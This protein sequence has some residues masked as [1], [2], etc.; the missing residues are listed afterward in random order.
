MRLRL[1]VPLGRTSIIECL[2]FAVTGAYPPGGPK[3]QTFV[4]DPKKLNKD[5][6]KAKVELQFQNTGGRKNVVVRPVEVV[7][8]KGVSTCKQQEG[9]LTSWDRAGNPTTTK[10]QCSDLNPT[11]ARLREYS[12]QIALFMCP[13]SPPTTVPKA[14]GISIKNI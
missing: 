8:K 12:I 3:S 7:R 5:T 10:I 6:V 4:Y 9:D 13:A 11:I 1:F 14:I 2:N